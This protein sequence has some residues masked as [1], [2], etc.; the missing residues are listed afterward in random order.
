MDWLTSTV[1]YRRYL[2]SSDPGRFPV[3][4]GWEFVLGCVVLL[5][6]LGLPIF[7]VFNYLDATYHTPESRF[8]LDIHAPFTVTSL[9]TLAAIWAICRDRY[10]FD[11][12]CF[13][14]LVPLNPR[15]ILP[16]MACGVAIAVAACLVYLPLIDPA[17]INSLGYRLDGGVPVTIRFVLTEFVPVH[18]LGAALIGPLLEELYRVL[19]YSWLRRHLNCGASLLLTAVLHALLH[20]WGAMTVLHFILGLA[21]GY[22]YERTRCLLSP[23]VLH[24][25]YNLSIALVDPAARQWLFH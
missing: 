17:H 20:G 11:I 19:L 21:W 5:C 24:G 4:W 23:Y 18:V 7:A 1:A 25:S 16:A 2:Q 14:G 9:V 15:V 3:P 6:A 22:A 12:E 13:L 10:D 8:F